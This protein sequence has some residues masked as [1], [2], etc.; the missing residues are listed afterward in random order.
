MLRFDTDPAEPGTSVALRFGRLAG[1]TTTSATKR[2]GGVDLFVELG[3]NA[4]AAGLEL[5]LVSGGCCASCCVDAGAGV[6]GV[7]DTGAVCVVSLVGAAL[8]VAG[9][10]HFD[11]RTRHSRQR[12]K[13][14]PGAVRHL[15]PCFTQ[16]VHASGP[17][18]P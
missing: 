15:R 18:Y 14:R 4:P 3:V 9:K 7:A 12:L 10:T 1:V 6:C 8:L 13:R 2:L 17:S 11:W 5:M 16:F